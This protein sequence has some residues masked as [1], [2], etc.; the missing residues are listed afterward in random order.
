MSEW[1]VILAGGRGTRLSSLIPNLPKPMAPVLGSPFLEWILRW[2]HLCGVSNVVVSTGYLGDV[3]ID[4]ISS[5]TF[6]GLNIKCVHEPSVL[7][8]GGGAILAGDQIPS[9]GFYLLNGD[10]FFPF[11]LEKINRSKT[12]VVGSSVMKGD[13]YG[14]IEANPSGVVTSFSAGENSSMVS[15]GV[16]WIKKSDLAGISRNVFLSMELDIFPK[17]IEEG[18]L[19][20]QPSKVP[21]HDMGIPESYKDSN[22]FLL[23]YFPFPQ[24]L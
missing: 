19:F 9:D 4:Y 20:L 22:R 5:R 17:L 10:C 14:S 23:T 6:D 16:Y 7:G 2:C 13:R 21:F 1:A 12:T 15:A 24:N 3:I 18:S 11:P 8:T